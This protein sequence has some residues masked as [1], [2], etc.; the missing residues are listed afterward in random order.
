LELLVAHL[1]G[2]E[3]E[4]V[5]FGNAHLDGLRVSSGDLL[6]LLDRLFLECR[7]PLYLLLLPQDEGLSVNVQIK[8]LE[9]GEPEVEIQ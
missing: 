1:S 4:M 7:A 6:I 5:H 8:D 2:L 3:N 9:E